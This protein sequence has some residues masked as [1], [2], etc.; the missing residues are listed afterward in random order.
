MNLPR[1]PSLL[2]SSLLAAVAV[3]VASAASLGS[4]TPPAACATPGGWWQASGTIPQP[5]S[6]EEVLARAAA[7]EI[8]LL[9]EQHDDEDH[10]R[11]QAQ[12]LAG[13]HALRPDMVIGFEMFPRQVQPALERWVAGELTVPAFLA[14]TAWTERWS[15]PIEL[16]LPLFEFARIN[17]IPM[18]ALNVD[19]KLT[20]A[21]GDKGWN[22]IPERE[23][24]GVGR[25][26]PASEAY[27][28]FLF[29]VY[30]EHAHRQD[31]RSNRAFQ[32][33]VEAQ[34][35]WDRAMAEALLARRISGPQ[36][37]PPLIVGIM[38]SGHLRYGL[39]VPHQLRDLG[40]G[41]VVTLL[42]FS[43]DE[44]CHEIRPGLADAL[45]SLPKK[46]APPVSPPRLG[47]QLDD[48]ESGQFGVRVL[49]VTAGSLAD[50]S[51]LLA[52]DRLL[53]VAGRRAAKAGMVIEAVRASPPG[54]WLPLRVK[55]GEATLDVVIRFP[56]AP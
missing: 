9:G 44:D 28:D 4:S 25:A 55:R 7:A 2:L 5:V 27:R 32:Y 30:S 49:A 36:G 17:R 46:P 12:V 53:E 15:L 52:G 1:T 22:A 16:Y 51:G 37:Q 10:H 39:G 34:Q 45:F 56:S 13:L 18:I 19:A 47:V 3:L 42:P 31:A 24:E 54:T 40:V 21:I 48:A 41:R 14:Q 50:N 26:A 20:R 23:R 38:G 29:G 11:W 8:V 35:N 33:F 6:G 43:P